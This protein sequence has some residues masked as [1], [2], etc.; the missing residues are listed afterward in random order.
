M[1]LMHHNKLNPYKI[2]NFL[3]FFLF[4][5]QLTAKS[6]DFT[7][8]PQEQITEASTANEADYLSVEE[9]K[10]IMYMNLARINGPLFAS[11]F[12]NNYVN[13]NNADKKSSDIQS[14]YQRLEKTIGLEPFLPSKQLSASAEYHAKDMGETGAAGHK[15]SDGT[16]WSVRIRSFGAGG[17]IAENCSYGKSDPL[18]IVIQLLIDKDVPGHGHRENILSRVYRSVGVAIEPHKRYRTN[19]VQDFS[20]MLPEKIV[21]R[22]TETPAGDETKK[23]FGIETRY[24]LIYASFAKRKDAEQSLQ[25]LQKKFENAKIVESD[26]RFRVSLNDFPV[27]KQA[28]SWAELLEKPYNN[29]VWVL[30]YP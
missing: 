6:Q 7:N 30:D 12:L 27:R 13:A 28:A 5:A 24:Y 10:L 25:S 19:S 17:A 23:D 22:A 9:K 1:K 18:A 4:I 3:I 21:E 2:I 14:L 8:W 15:S 26:G 29:K 11:T 16:P 20:S